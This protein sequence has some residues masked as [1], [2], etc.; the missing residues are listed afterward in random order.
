MG[1]LS[2]SYPFNLASLSFQSVKLI[3]VW[4]ATVLGKHIANREKF[5]I[6]ADFILPAN[7]EDIIN[8]PR[9]IDIL[10]GVAETF[11]DAVLQFVSSDS[12]LRYKWI[13]YLPSGESLGRVW[14]VLPPEI[15]RLLRDENILYSQECPIPCEPNMLQILPPTHLDSSGLPLF[16]DRPGANRKYLSLR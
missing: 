12:P 13:K 2:H 7:R 1:L 3:S 9:N 11:R 4:V 14:E 6:Q 8:T 15:I 5:I 16:H 10:Q